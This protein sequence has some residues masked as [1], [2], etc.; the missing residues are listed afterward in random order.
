MAAVAG[1]LTDISPSDAARR[2][3]SHV[4]ISIPAMSAE[5]LPNAEQPSTPDSTDMSPSA[6]L[7]GTSS[8][9]QGGCDSL[10]LSAGPA[11]RSPCAVSRSDLDSWRQDGLPSHPAASLKP[12]RGLLCKSR[13]AQEQAASVLAAGDAHEEEDCIVC[14]SAAPCVIFQPC[15]HLCCCK[16]CAQP[17]VAAGALCPMCRG[18]VLSML[19][20]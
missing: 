17:V 20:M 2:D 18:P 1:P 14:W 3:S 7:V 10:S 11:G 15:G 5:L 6:P 8:D 16:A 4:P 9:L 12:T 13:H 19:N